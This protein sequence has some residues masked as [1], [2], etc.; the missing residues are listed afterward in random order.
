[1]VQAARGALPDWAADAAA[2]LRLLDAFQAQ[3]EQNR[4]ALAG[5]IARETG[6]PLWESL[7][8]VA[9]MINK[10]PLSRAAWRERAGE[11]R[12]DTPDARSVVRHKPHGVV[13][14]LGPF[15]FPGHLPNGHIVPALLAGNTV[16]F[17]PS[18]LTPRV[19]QKTLE[20]WQAAGL[21]PGVINLVQGGRDTATQLAGHAGIDGLFFTG[22]PAA[23]KALH[24]LFAGQPGR[25]LAL[26]MGGNN[27]LIVHRVADLDAAAYHV[28]QSAYLSAG[29]RCTCARRLIVPR[30]GD[31]DR[32]IDRLA[33]RLAGVRV[34]PWTD[35]PEPFMGPVISNGAADRLLAFQAQ[36][37][38]GGGRPLVA[39]RRLV[40]H[41]PFLTPGLLDATACRRP[42]E[43]AFGPL[44][45]VIRT[46]DFPAALAEANNTVYGLAAGLLSDDRPLFEEFYR[47][48]RAG[49]V[50]WNRPLT[51]ASSAAPFGGV[52][53]SG[54]L[55]PSA[56]YAADYCA[57]PVASLEAE[58]VTLPKALTPGISL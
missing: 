9:A 17:K 31:G 13:A 42:D 3:L 45:Q 14:V 16:V 20:L 21:P 50:N 41:R 46:A 40:E 58:R 22:S 37:E 24:R 19:A 47:A 39:M 8:E 29:Q 28:I 38:A 33:Q 55:R 2:R 57:Y 56:Y 44:L 5:S 35:R 30:G 27:P 51:G 18:E 52:G 1:A 10:I 48:I 23:G 6:K 34:G 53:E 26:E 25:I 12:A 32:F 11:R 36:L 7:T 4:S 15:N 49:V 54:N 43:E